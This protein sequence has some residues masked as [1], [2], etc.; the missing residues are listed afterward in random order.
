MTQINKLTDIEE[1]TIEVSVNI[2]YSPKKDD[3]RLKVKTSSDFPGMVQISYQELESS[4]FYY[5]TISDLCIDK[6][7]WNKLNYAVETVF[8]KTI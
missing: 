5:K 4:G 3:Y 6:D 1:N 7:M 2:Y 8:E